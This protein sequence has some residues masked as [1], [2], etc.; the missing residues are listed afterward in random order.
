MGAK[1]TQNQTENNQHHIKV[2]RKSFKNRDS[3]GIFLDHGKARA[4]IKSDQNLSEK[5]ETNVKKLLKFN[6]KGG[7]VGTSPQQVSGG[8]SKVIENN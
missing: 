3:V 2:H 4:G 7:V 1:S 6:Q 8:G 5:N